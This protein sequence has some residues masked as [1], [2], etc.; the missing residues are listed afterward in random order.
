MA[1]AASFRMTRLIARQ[2]RSS[3][4][5]AAIHFPDAPIPEGYKHVLVE[6]S[7]PANDPKAVLAAI[8]DHEDRFPQ[9][10]YRDD[11]NLL[12]AGALMDDRQYAQALLLVENI[13]RNPKQSDLHVLAA[14]E[15][16]D[17]AQQLL[18]PSKR[19]AIA[20][21]FR[22]TPGAM[23]HLRAVVKGDTFLSR[24]H[25]LMAWVEGQK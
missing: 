21:A 14:L 17:M 3:R 13:L 7:N 24:L 16:A 25:P 6:R 10:R 22:R 18:E 4:R 8:R 9:G 23:A 19:A 20:I 12:R 1:E 2:F 5:I 11:L 15:F